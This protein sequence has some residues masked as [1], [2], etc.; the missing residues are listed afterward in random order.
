VL[1]ELPDRGQHRV[2]PAGGAQRAPGC[3][4]A[5]PGRNAAP[6]RRTGRT[7]PAFAASPAR[8]PHTTPEQRQ[9]PRV[10]LRRALCA[11]PAQPDVQQPLIGLGHRPVRCIDHRPVPVTRHAPAQ[12]GV[13]QGGLRLDQATA[14]FFSLT[15]PRRARPTPPSVS[16]TRGGRPAWVKCTG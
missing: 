13:T 5:R 10:R 4:R 15:S 16:P 11:V 8:L 3:R 9:R 1:E 2:H 14:A 6:S 7:G 12:D